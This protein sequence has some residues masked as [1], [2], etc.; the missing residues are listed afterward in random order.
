MRRQRV[1]LRGLT[2]LEEIIGERG[3]RFVSIIFLQNSELPSAGPITQRPDIMS[4]GV[5]LRK[6][7]SYRPSYGSL[8]RF[9]SH[10]ETL[11]EEAGKLT[12]PFTGC[13][14]SSRC[15]VTMHLSTDH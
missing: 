11:Q 4:R 10:R 14:C 6:E 15:I 8:L 12:T 13:S 5:R 2:S 1:L 3:A 9:S 7:T